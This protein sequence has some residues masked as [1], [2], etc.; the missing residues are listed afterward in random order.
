ME[1]DPHLTTGDWLDEWLALLHTRVRRTTHA[2]Y[3]RM[4]D[5]YLRPH[6][7]SIPLTELTAHHLDRLY[8]DLLVGGGRDGRR[9]ARGTVTHAHAVLRIAL[10]DALDRGLV[11]VN[12]ATKAHVPRYDPEADLAPTPLATWDAEQTRRFLAC[13]ATHPLHDLWRVALGTGMRRA[14]LLGLRWNDV[15]LAAAQLRVNAGLTEVGGVLKLGR[16]KTGRSRTLFLDQ[17]TLAAIDRQPRTV[18]THGYGL[19][20]T[21]PDTSPWPPTIV[22]DRWRSQWPR[23]AG[24]GVPKIR[25][26]ATRHVHATLLLAQGVP[27]KV[28]SERLGHSTIAMTMDIY[29]HVLPAMDRD[30][31]EAIGRALA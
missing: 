27:I 13:T 26:H 7:G 6:I 14:E 25:L 30:A 16:P 2:T 28:V 19:V 29:A 8:V 1:T 15:D 11:R 12:V 9:L 10:S 21:R 20:F 31:A 5:A 18:D 24:L 3:R 22:T 17:A 23:L 4:V